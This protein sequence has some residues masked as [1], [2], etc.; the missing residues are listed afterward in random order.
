MLLMPRYIFRELVVMS[1][2]RFREGTGHCSLCAPLAIIGRG[3]TAPLGRLPEK[4]HTRNT[5]RTPDYLYARAGSGIPFRAVMPD[6]RE[7]NTYAKAE[8]AIPQT[9]P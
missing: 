2:P 8:E 6:T 9:V 7:S 1:M 5:E 3:N 4:C